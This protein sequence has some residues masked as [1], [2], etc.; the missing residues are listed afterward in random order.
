MGDRLGPARDVELAEYGRGVVGDR[1]RGYAQSP[2]DGCICESVG[3]EFEHLALAPRERRQ[4]RILLPRH[5]EVRDCSPR[6][7]GAEDRLACSHAGDGPQQVLRL[8]TFEH[9]AEGAGAHCR[10]HGLLVVEHCEHQDPD[11]WCRPDDLACGVDPGPVGHA[12]VEN[13]HVGPEQDGLTDGIAT[14]PGRA[15]ALVA[16]DATDQG[17]QPLPDD[18]VVIG[19]QDPNGHRVAPSGIV[20]DTPPPSGTGPAS[21]APPTST[22][23][24]RIDVSPT[25]GVQLLGPTPAPA[26]LSLMTRLRAS[27]SAR[28]STTA[29][30]AT[31]WRE[32]LVSASVAILYAATSAAAGNGGSGS[33]AWMRI[34]SG[35]PSV[36]RDRM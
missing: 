8:G 6:D 25:P 36:R 19:D 18:R 16:L 26:P 4:C 9:V 20:T 23:R 28:R 7:A 33:S 14:R 12:D 11:I 5:R 29:A 30:E 17:A 32:I 34:S 35:A 24:S 15:D 10:E 3:D 1:V 22:A 31:E 27:T 21:Y 2:G 13:E